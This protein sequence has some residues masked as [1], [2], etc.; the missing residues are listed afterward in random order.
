[1][2][3]KWYIVIALLFVAVIILYSNI[4]VNHL[5]EVQNFFDLNITKEFIFLFILNV[6][7]GLLFGV[8]NFIKNFSLS[9]KWHFNIIR[10]VILGV[11]ALFFSFSYLSFC[12]LYFLNFPISSLPLAAPLREGFARMFLGYTLISS[13]YKKN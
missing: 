2:K 10:F 5:V 7:M 1:M 11:P 3:R 6:F 8:E 12:L 13:I 4:Y 9:G